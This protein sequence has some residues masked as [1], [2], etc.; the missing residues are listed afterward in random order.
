M[1]AGKLTF[2]DNLVPKATRGTYTVTV[3]HEVFSGDP[4][5]ASL[6]TATQTVH[7]AG[8]RLVLAEGDVHGVY[9][10]RGSVGAYTCLLPHISL[11]R[12]VLPWENRLKGAP[13]ETPWFALLVFGEGELLDDPHCLGE[14]EK[15][16]AEDLLTPSSPPADLALPAITLA[17]DEE[18]KLGVQTVR[19]RAAVFKALVPSLD[20]LAYRTHVRSPLPGESRAGD[21]ER[22]ELEYAFA[23]SDRLPAKTGGRY[24][25]HLVSLE[26]HEAH[27]TGAVGKKNIRLLSLHSWTF[28]S[29]ADTGARTFADIA[30][31][32]VGPGKKRPADLLLSPTAREA[33][34]PTAYT[35]HLAHRLENGWAPLHHFG[36]A[37]HGYVFYRGPLVPFPVKPVT[38]TGEWWKTTADPYSVR[39]TGHHA[40]WT[41]GRGLA[42]ADQEFSG[43]LARH[44]ARAHKTLLDLAV[45]FAAEPPPAPAGGEAD[46]PEQDG[47]A[48]GLLP[49]ALFTEGP[50]A[51]ALARVLAGEPVQRH[52]EAL[53]EAA[54]QEGADEA[55]QGGPE[56]AAP[57]ETSYE[58][59]VKYLREGDI[60]FPSAA[61][62]LQEAVESLTANTA[63][64]GAVAAHALLPASATGSVYAAEEEEAPGYEPALGAWLDGLRLLRPV[65]FDHLVPHASMLPVESLRLFR[66]DPDWLDALTL[67][68]LAA[69]LCLAHDPAQITALWNAYKPHR[70]TPDTGLL[71]RSELVSAFPGLRVE[72]S[73]EHAGG[74]SGDPCSVLRQDRLGPDVLLVLFKGR[75]KTVSL[76]EPFH[77]LHLGMEK[78]A[79]PHDKSDWVSMRHLDKANLGTALPKND[80]TSFA[81][82]PYRPKADTV[83][84][85][86]DLAPATGLPA[87]LWAALPAKAKPKNPSNE[88]EVDPA[89]PA[90]T[91][92][93][94]L[95]LQ[96]IQSPERTEITVPES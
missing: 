68:A 24:V 11:E 69:G 65:P 37:D 86:I 43:A 39:E 19:T 50:G 26:G 6:P 42:L 89:H 59:L 81:A 25:A 12:R 1:T 87:T 61:P 3:D 80:D 5:A 85:I 10:P 7:I 63:V 96:M 15:G 9:P 14:V 46:A 54:A 23:M 52:L 22:R 30:A 92:P 33:G 41:L 73:A 35:R 13:A 8:A 64:T 31:Q 62:P 48:D 72:A 20:V 58:D 84:R 83:D 79:S 60:N 77:G 18:K 32:L 29:T 34:T 44:L 82:V 2:S 47:G 66:V 40:A 36:D 90:R 21:A 51:E 76:L 55:Q 88:N 71:I 17:D 57:A 91:T 93:A 28:T 67:G 53:T 95:A 49:E 27:V 75:P 56:G 16:K 4:D 74:A 94:E 78:R 38:Q 45:V 70:T